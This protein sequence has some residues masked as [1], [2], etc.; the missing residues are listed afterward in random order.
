MSSLKCS[1][2][3]PTYNTRELTL[4]CLASIV[5]FPP[6]SDYEVIVID[7]HSSDN[8][9]EQIRQQFPNV[10]AIRNPGNLGFARACNRGAHEAKGELLLFLNSDTQVLQG[11]FAE[12]LR[13]MDENPSTGIV[14]PELIGPGPHLLQMSW[15]WHPLNGG[16]IL[17]RYFAPQHI[18]PRGFKQQLIRRLQ[19]S[20]RE[21][22]F[23]CGA[24]LL[25]RRNVFDQ[26]NGFDESFEL[27]FEDTD[28]CWRCDNAGWKVEFVPTSKIIHHIGQ[29]TK[30]TWS[31]SS[32]IYQQSHITFYRK[33]ASSFSVFF[34][35]IYL[36]LK[37]LR[38]WIASR[39]DSTEPLRA[40]I[41][42]R[43]YLRVI[44]ES[45]RFA[46]DSEPGVSRAAKH[47]LTWNRCVQVLSR[48]AFTRRGV[49]KNFLRPGFEAHEA[50]F[51]RYRF[52]MD[53]SLGWL[54]R[55]YFL[56]PDVYEWETQEALRRWVRPGMTVFDIGAHTGYMTIL[57]AHL[58]GPRG[59]VYAFEPASRIYSLL[60]TNVQSNP[61]PQVAVFQ[62]ALSDRASTA[63]LYLNP[64]NDGNN[65]LGNVRESPDFIGIN[66]EEREEK[67]ATE[68]LD[69][70]LA[71]HGIDHVDLIKIDVEGAEPLVFSGARDLLTRQDA[72]PIICEVG[73]MNQ[74]YFGQK[75]E[76]LRKL[77]YD[78]G[79]HSY[80]IENFREFGPRTP[81][82]GLRNVLFTKTPI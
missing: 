62:L 54:Q 25:I 39:F 38:I 49:F 73:D 29:S 3:I 37:W 16:E 27:Y 28:L 45:T 57:L 35:K 58:V 4:A 67:V 9:Y 70:F 47:Q 5:R 36:L 12:L 46:L 15:S 77:L 40:K 69:H 17:H 19:R 72:P 76:E 71:T 60:K 78:L 59:R 51:G 79:Y 64:N 55:I 53:L 65:S 48:I 43:S 21:V 11:T 81:V 66:V 31:M 13:W 18:A 33:H 74:P 75:E 23:I 44:F 68:T 1:I 52:H 34:L 42:C 26:L 24:C 56:K 8:T 20:A 7:N 6:P 61:L 2:I 10:I 22:P 82:H 14:G 41:Y 80:W 50:L 63:S 32:L 30:G